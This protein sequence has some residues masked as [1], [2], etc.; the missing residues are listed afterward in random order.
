MLKIGSAYKIINKDIDAFFANLNYASTMDSDIVGHIFTVVGLPDT[1][2]ENW[3]AVYYRYIVL[4]NG[5]QLLYLFR[6]EAATGKN[7]NKFLEEV[8]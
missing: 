5:Q 2:E 7:P 6:S 8:K 3:Y 4:F 1:P